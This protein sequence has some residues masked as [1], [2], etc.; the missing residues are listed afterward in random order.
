MLPRI[1]LV[2]AKHGPCSINC[3]GAREAVPKSSFITDSGSV[4]ARISADRPEPPLCHGFG[5]S[6]SAHSERLSNV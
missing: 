6:L 5:G 4:A 1:D 2:V 3:L